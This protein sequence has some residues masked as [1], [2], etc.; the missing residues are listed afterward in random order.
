MD[1]YKKLAYNVKYIVAVSNIEIHT[2]LLVFQ[3]RRV[4]WLAAVRHYSVSNL[5]EWKL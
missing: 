5:S 2:G 4:N 3:E 1:I